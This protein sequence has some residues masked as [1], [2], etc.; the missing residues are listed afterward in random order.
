MKA[1]TVTTYQIQEI[2]PAPLTF[3]TNPKV[4]LPLILYNLI[5]DTNRG[6]EANKV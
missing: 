6:N 3:S 5:N 4:N 2:N 1:N